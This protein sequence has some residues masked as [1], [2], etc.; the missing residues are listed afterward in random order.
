MGLS[1]LVVAEPGSAHG[2]AELVERQI[3]FHPHGER[4]RHDLEVERTVIARRDL[5]EAVA[6]IG[7]DACEHVDAPRRA[8]GV[9]LAPQARWEIEALL[10]FDQVRAAGLEHRP[11]A[12]Q[13]D[14]VED[15]VLQFA[16][17]RVGARQEAAADAQGTLA[18]AQIEAGRLHVGVWDLEPP[19]VDVPRVDG[20][21]EELAREHPLRG[22]VE[23]QD[24]AHSRVSQRR[25]ASIDRAKH[26][27]PSRGSSN[28]G[29]DAGTACGRPGDGLTNR[30]LCCA[31]GVVHRL[32]KKGRAAA[33]ASAP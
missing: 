23:V 19:G 28:L 7:D 30:P 3:L 16:L 29:T 2:E 12:A 17:H 14:L 9:R 25:D 6:V 5:V 15:V 1:H 20:S 27:V 18:E 33:Q 21:L 32:G 8:L 4:Q 26:V 10:E 22:G 11:L 13:V 31:D 24:H